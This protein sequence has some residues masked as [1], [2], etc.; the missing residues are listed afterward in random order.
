MAGQGRPWTSLVE[1]VSTVRRATALWRAIVAWAALLCALPGLASAETMRL[2]IAWGG[3]DA[4][5]WEGSVSVEQG[6]VLELQPLG[7][8]ADEPGSM[9]IEPDPHTGGNRLHVQAKSVRSYDGVDLLVDAPLDSKLLLEFSAADDPGQPFRAEVVLAELVVREPFE[10]ELNERKNRLL[11]RRTPGDMLRIVLKRDSLVFSPGEVLQFTIEPHLLP[12]AGDTKIRLESRL[13]RAGSRE[14]L[15]STEDEVNTG[16]D[17]SLF[18]ELQLPE[19]EGVY[20]LIIT[21]KRAAGWV[22]KP[23]DFSKPLVERKI[24]MLV[25]RDESPRDENAMGPTRREGKLQEVAVID[26]ANPNWPE[27]LGLDKL[28]KLPKIPRWFKGPIG[29]D[30]MQIVMHRLSKLAQLNPNRQSPDVSWEAYPL[31]IKEPGRPHVIE[32]A[33]PSDVA[34]TLAIS[35]MEQNAVG[36]VEPIGLDSG[37]ERSKQLAAMSPSSKW[38]HHRVVFWPRTSTP[39]LVLA[40]LRDDQPA[41][42]G[43]IRVLSGWDHLPRAIQGETLPQERLLAAYMDRPLFPENFS[44]T[45][46]LD[47]L[48]NRSLDDWRTFHEGGTRL[49]EYLQYAGY[50]GLMISVLADG[51]TI[52]PSKILEPTPRY[53][54]GI[55]FATGQDP[56]RK[57]VLEMLLRLFD[58]EGLQLIPTLDFSA[59]LPQLEAML[60]AGAPEAQSI[61]WIGPEGNSLSETHSARRGLAPYYNTTNP[62]VQEAMLQVV[63]EVMD[64]CADHPSFGGLA[65]RLSAHGYAQL[66]GPEWGLDDETIARFC[67]DVKIKPFGS[68]PDR[69]AQRAR[70]LA[71]KNYRQAWLQWRAAQLGRLYRGIQTELTTI[72]PESRLY[73]AGA[74]MLSD[75]TI[76]KDLLP[77]LPRRKSMAE[78]L[79]RVGIDAED[80][81]DANGP[82]LLR[83]ERIVSQTNLGAQAVSLEISQFMDI[84]TVFAELP[85]SGSLFFHPPREVRIESF[86]RKSPFQPCYAQLFSQPVPSGWQNRRRFVHSIATLDSRVLVDGGWMLPLG[87]EDSMREVVAA[88]RRLPAIEYRRVGDRHRATRSQPV[89]IRYGRYRNH[90]YVYAANDAPFATKVRLRVEAAPG[91]RLEELTG[92][93]R[94]GPLQRDARGNYWMVQLKPYD[95]LAARLS[96]PKAK[97]SEPK[98]YLP[99]SA[100]VALGQQI[101]ELVTRTA[102][103]DQPPPLEVLSNPGFEQPA[104]EGN[105]LPGWDTLQRGNVR[106]EPDVNRPHGG[107]RSVKMTS[108]GP[109]ACLVSRPF[110]PPTTGRLQIVVRL[111]VAD[112]KAQPSL[113]LALQWK[114]RSEV[115]YVSAPVGSAPG[116]E[117]KIGIQWKPYSFSIND[118]PLQDL[119]EMQVR[120]D[121]QGPG[122]VWIDDVQLSCLAFSKNEIRELGSLITAAHV[123]LQEDEVGDCLRLLE[124]YW[125]RFLEENVPLKLDV[126]Q[127]PRRQPVPSPEEKKQPGM[128]DGIRNL[129][130]KQFR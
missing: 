83:P 71:G 92:L 68:G 87:Q 9:W 1:C 44:A 66:P 84:D 88:Y 46:S 10:W 40:N 105:A 16:G 56:V 64:R 120:F 86:D 35:V 90:S 73:L 128:F 28:P 116:A 5:L 121:L 109:W 30:N 26:P 18:V 108:D 48:S 79:L 69:F 127:R 114:H 100:T 113:W 19:E 107:Q 82:V 52:Y 95:L 119:S 8:E 70:T 20:D 77:K 23:L 78:T 65:I 11:V 57:D 59:P 17:A 106:I 36:A 112:A 91:C 130:P 76:Q 94:V 49:V 6:T 2:R 53:D 96:D 42:Y 3:G 14:K 29:N 50:N 34:Q 115:D 117:A 27:K 97:F 72:R 102:S 43:K 111:R 122:E 12:V 15:W 58:R 51:S 62:I 7:V 103:L 60:R 61:Q 63:R 38:E 33:Y 21:A 24:Q 93:R 98:I 129:L 85:L 125:P 126:A 54:R 101:R 124:G 80:Y 81:R 32:I 37:I 110:E 99:K 4:R 47:V 123:T 22:R 104:S 25:L 45:E 89:T 55:F 67:R 41:M 118:L 75:K 13:V 39:L 31:P 74:E